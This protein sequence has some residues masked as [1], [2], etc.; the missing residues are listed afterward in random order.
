MKTWR[1]PC[2]ARWIVL[3]CV[4]IACES[5]S[6]THA[7]TGE[8]VSPFDTSVATD[9]VCFPLV[10]RSEVNSIGG[11]S[12]DSI[13]FGSIDGAVVLA[14]GTIAIND[15]RR[16]ALHFISLQGYSIVGAVGAGPGEFDGPVSRIWRVGQ[17]TLAV[18]DRSRV[19][20][21]G[22]DGT[23]IGVMPAVGADPIGVRGILPDGRTLVR[24]VVTR[25]S[26]TSHGAWRD[27]VRLVAIG[28]G[29]EDAITGLLPDA[30]R[31]MDLTNGFSVF[32]I[33]FGVRPTYEVFGDQ[34]L[35]A[36]GEKPEVHL[37]NFTGQIRTITL[38]LNGR[39]VTAE[40]RRAVAVG[41]EIDTWVP[42]SIPPY[43]H[44]AVDDAGW[45]WIRRYPVPGEIPTWI[46]TDQRGALRQEL[47]L[48]NGDEFLA[49]NDT[50]ALFRVTGAFDTP[51][52]MILGRACQ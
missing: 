10:A 4:P 31:Y 15:R 17:D 34:I 19:S 5:P 46:I 26:P 36:P 22:P 51:S 35:L 52:L 14:T 18:H 29:G 21:F 37:M 3:A 39:P 47:E 49:A 40:M 8:P 50:I 16:S 32:L 6:R 41:G 12:G 25:N 7:P 13:W 42:D 27:S 43:Q 23:F 11:T 33:P 45:I 2:S 48:A 20:R 9:G 44:A 28:Q 24:R 30:D 38:P 1:T